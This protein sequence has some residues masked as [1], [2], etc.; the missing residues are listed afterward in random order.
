MNYLKKNIMAFK[1]M[2]KDDNNI[3]EKSVIG[4]MSFSIM[5]IFAIVDLITGY[6]GKDLVINE[7]IYDSFTL[8]TLGCFGIAGLE[9][10]FGKKEQN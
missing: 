10:I 7:F 6:V 9:K 5:V 4:F 2:F 3:N 1:N 8:M